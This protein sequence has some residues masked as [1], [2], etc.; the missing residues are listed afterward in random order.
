MTFPTTDAAATDRS[1]DVPRLES[2]LRAEMDGEVAFD[3][4]S[5]HIFSRDASMYSITPLGVV[6][7]RHADDVAAAVKGAGELGV[8]IVARG[9]GTS[10]ASMALLRRIPVRTSW[11]ST[12]AAAGWPARSVSSRSVTTSPS[13][14]AEIGF[15][16]PSRRSQ[17]KRSWP[18]P[19]CRAGNRSS[20]E[21]AAPRGTRLSWCARRWPAPAEDRRHHA[22]CSLL[23]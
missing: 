4:Y 5:R 21:L 12:P 14:S 15:S 19:V 23:A 20:T 18:R 7:P 2:A 1:G 22:F 16:R 3:D 9:A 6:F 10:P 11:R 8:P 17:R 13:P